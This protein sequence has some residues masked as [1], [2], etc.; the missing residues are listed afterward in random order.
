MARPGGNPDRPPL[1]N[2]PGHGRPKGSKNKLTRERVEQEL[3]FLAFSDPIELFDRVAKGRRTFR[4]KE[5]N[6]MSPETRRCIASVK[7]K[8]ENLTAGDEKQDTTVEVRLWDKTRALEM[9]GR[10]LG[11]FKDKIEI[12]TDDELLSRLDRAKIRAR[13]EK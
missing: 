5:I 3:R 12:T 4:L 7:V 9:C 13:G 6:E 10:A 2:G 11:M 1:P 8:T